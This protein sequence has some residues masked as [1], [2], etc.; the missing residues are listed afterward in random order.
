LLIAFG[1]KLNE[2]NKIEY[3]H[4]E[5]D[6][7][8]LTVEGRKVPCAFTERIPSVYKKSQTDFIDELIRISHS[9]KPDKSQ[10]NTASIKVELNRLSKR[11]KRKVNNKTCR[12]TF[13]RKCMDNNIDLID[14]SIYLGVTLENLTRIIKPIKMEERS[15]NQNK[16]LGILMSQTDIEL[17]AYILSNLPAD[18]LPEIAEE[19]L[20]EKMV[21]DE[22]VGGVSRLVDLLNRSSREAEKIIV[23]S[24]EKKQPQTAEEIKRLLFTM[25][26]LVLLDDKSIQS[27]LREIDSN[28]IAMA[29][30]G[31]N[32]DAR[33]RVYSNL[34]ERAYQQVKREMSVVNNGAIPV[35]QVEE[36]QQKVINILRLMESRGEIKISRAGE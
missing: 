29:L 23:M 35:F 16:A 17:S 21:G 6:E 3:I 1:I 19:I 30:I 34:S 24:L 4:A 14:I 12:N 10:F 25:N 36:A 33:Q 15:M 31:V 32:E 8:Y 28:D 11:V 26:D 7:C 18:N 9:Y 20:V 13:I 5:G 22:R 2:L 27:M